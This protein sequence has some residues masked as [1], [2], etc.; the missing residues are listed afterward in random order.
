[1]VKYEIGTCYGC[2]KCMYC[3]CDLNVETC[4]CDK[5]VKPRKENRT[6][7]VPH[8]FGR[9]FDNNLI[10]N[11]KAF[12]QTQNVLYSYNSDL[13]NRF[14]FTLCSTCN[15]SFQR[16]STTKTTTSSQDSFSQNTT[17]Q[18]KNIIIIDDNFHK[19]KSISFQDESNDEKSEET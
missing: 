4:K 3:G 6:S 1:M 12:I 9:I 7:Q 15:S 5:T 14:S 13:K 10:L 18:N 11:K 19:D 8:T 2:R 17:S 16:L